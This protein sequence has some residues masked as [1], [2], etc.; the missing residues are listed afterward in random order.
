LGW[1]AWGLGRGYGMMTGVYVWNVQDL[2]SRS[3]RSCTA[4]SG[5][6]RGEPWVGLVGVVGWWGIR[7]PLP[8]ASMAGFSQ[9]WGV[10]GGL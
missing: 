9:R 8:L 5:Q 6:G 7:G 4:I 3:N 2:G 1:E 10:G